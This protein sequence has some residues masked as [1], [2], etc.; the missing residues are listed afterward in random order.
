ME[1]HRRA[2]RI[3]LMVR[4]LGVSCSGYYAW[5][6]RVDVSERQHAREKRDALVAQAFAARKSRYGSPRLVL[7]LCDVGHTCNRKTV[8]SSLRRQGLRAKAAKR[9]KVT[10][11][12]K[13]DLPVAA[14]LLE[15]NFNA[16]APN[17]KWVGDITYLWTDEGWLY[18]ATVLDLY[19]RR[20]IGW[21][22]SER[23]T[24][25]L[26]CNAL[27]M[28]LWRRQ[29]PRGVIMHT[30]R[31]SQYCSNDYQRLLNKHGLVCS[32]SGKGNCYDNACA[33]SFFHTLKVE[34]IHGERFAMRGHM[35]Q[36]VFQYIE[37]D[38]NKTRRHGALGYISPEAFEASRV[39]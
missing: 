39:A 19:S 23:M 22:M 30:D 34:L 31:G 14:N 17:E 38:Y 24:A 15:Q 18:L 20:V 1:R 2:F 37:T 12:S 21:S 9:F 13:H 25:S 29:L 32:M 5:R 28:A 26:V 10:T 7:D 11:N 6:N 3:V 33:E 27:M 35:R 16:K 36:A 8:A 4:I